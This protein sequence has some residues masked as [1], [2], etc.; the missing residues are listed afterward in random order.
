MGMKL[1]KKTLT[2]I[3]KNLL[4]LKE[5]LEKSL[6]S[7]DDEV[8]A[9]GDSVDQIQAKSLIELNR[10]LASRDALLLKRINLFLDKMDTENINICL[11]CGEIIGEKRLM[12]TPGTRICFDCASDHELK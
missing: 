9:H 3:K 7:M 10:K 4:D 8:D 2:K 12:A 1:P 6:A 11:E 5:S